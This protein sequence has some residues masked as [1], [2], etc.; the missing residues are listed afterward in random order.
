MPAV[1]ERPVFAGAK[2]RLF[3]DAGKIL[4]FAVVLVITRSLASDQHMQY[5]VQIVIPL[6]SATRQDGTFSERISEIRKGAFKRVN[7]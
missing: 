2:E 1:A 7:P 5:V 6:R 4:N 3:Q